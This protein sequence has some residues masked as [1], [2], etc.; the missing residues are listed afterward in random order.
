M[1]KL[2]N[3]GIHSAFINIT[4]L[5]ILIPFITVESYAANI[6]SI[7]N[8]NWDNPSI[9]N[10]GVIPTALDNVTI[11]D[12]VT[13]LA[14]NPLYTVNSVSIDNSGR[15]LVNGNL[16]VNGN[17]SMTNNVEFIMNTPAIVIIKG[18]AMISNRT[19][20]ELASY[21]IVYGNFAKKGPVNQSTIEVADHSNIYLLGE[22]D[23]DFDLATCNTYSGSTASCNYGQIDDLITNDVNN[24][25]GLTVN[26][27]S[28]SPY[29]LPTTGIVTLTIAESSTIGSL[30]WFVN[31]TMLTPT[32]ITHPSTPYQYTANQTGTYNAM[33]KIDNIWFISN[34]VTVLNSTIPTAE[35]S[36]TT[37][38]CQGSTAT[39][40]FTLGGNGPWNFTY[41]NGTTPLT[42]TNQA[43]STY[44][45]G[46]TPVS[47]KTY[48]LTSINNNCNSGTIGG[49]AT[50]TVNA[51]G[52]WI[53]GTT[54]SLSDWKI[55]SNWGCG[56]IPNLTTDVLIPNVTYK[57]VLSAGS[58]SSAKNIVI[59]AGSSL[60]VTGN[61][62]QIAGT[63]SNSGTFIA[64]NGTIEMKG[65]KAQTIQASTFAGNNLLNLIVNNSAGVILGGVLNITGYIKTATG[66]LASNGNL[67]LISS[68]TKTALI[69]GSGNGQVTGNVVIQRHLAIGYGYKYFSS[70]FTTLTVNA[71]EPYVNLASTFPTFYKYNCNNSIGGLGIT[72][73]SG[74]VKWVNTANPM[75]PMAGYAV[76]FGNLSAPKT[77]NVSGVVSNGIQTTTLFNHNRTFTTGFN[78][79]GNPFPSPIDWIAA[80]GWTK[81]NIDNA[82]YLFDS[83]GA[84]DEY[85]GVYCSFVNGISTGG[86]TNII[87]SMQGFFV[88]VSDGTYPVTGSLNMT[89]SVRK[90]DFTTPFKS[91]SFDPRSILRFSAKFDLKGSISDQFV[92]YFDPY[93]S[94]LFDKEKDAL[95]LMNTDKMVPNLYTL[96]TDVRKVSIS[97]IPAPNDSI[98]RMP[99]GIKTSMDGW[100]NFD[101]MDISLLP[102]S[103]NIYL[104][105]SEKK[106]IQDLRKDSSYRF[107]LTSGENNQRFYLIFSAK[108]LTQS[109]PPK[110]RLFTLSRLFS[111]IFIN[112]NLPFDTDG[113]LIVSNML[114]QIML[115]KTVYGIETVEL[116]NNVSSGLYIISLISGKNR[117]SEKITI[118]KYYD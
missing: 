34:S 76:N 11:K 56:V 111:Q 69:D 30:K 55:A 96:T 17:F 2:V 105:D 5:L 54:G 21:Y 90:N 63:I 85:S 86:L 28:V 37:S 39:L 19:T 89:N 107:Y 70:P 109:S 104:V 115:R 81:T 67:K 26:N 114:G 77:V 91:A 38:I 27:L 53:G 97:G 29:C 6:S 9:W 12:E 41:T 35:I 83:S 59:I 78:L 108:D 68:A 46:V 117:D 102:T 113:N 66:N 110:E 82:I 112:V 32:D 23:S 99:I 88:H 95:K 92:I 8:G 80:S 25:L 93:S 50:V 33:Y 98:K 16:T 43:S 58:T 103:L 7:K 62:L 49:S 61:T 18:D 100:V 14:T 60:T 101:A 57:P 36:G 118:R 87:P 79:V 71:F 40:T 106:S 31:G 20:L 10:R 3:P 116:N 15:L 42:V 52:T 74:W 45:V 64:D 72:F 47:T 84:F 1:I 94:T 65:T 73:I 13:I 48:T 22:V 75:V 24:I 51:V 4:L 44:T